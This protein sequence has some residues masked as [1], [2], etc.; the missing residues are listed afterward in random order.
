MWYISHYS[1]ANSSLHFQ[2]VSLPH[3]HELAYSAVKCPSLKL[4]LCVDRQGIDSAHKNMLHVASG[5]YPLT[6]SSPSPVTSK[7]CFLLF[8]LLL[9]KAAFRSLQTLGAVPV[10]GF[11]HTASF[12][13]TN[14]NANR[15]FPSVDGNPSLFISTPN[16]TAG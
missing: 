16:S 1:S 10:A 2:L 13:E 6:F 5:I 12:Y 4:R 3:L 11:L 7:Y 9:V 8:S 15:S 14:Q